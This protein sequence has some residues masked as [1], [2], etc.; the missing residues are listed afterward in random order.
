MS[1]GLEFSETMAGT[2]RRADG[3]GGGPFRID[4]DVRTSKLLSPFGTTPGTYTGKLNA[5]GL[6]SGTAITGTLDF[7]PLKKHRLGYE[8]TTVADDGNSYRFDGWKTIRG[9]RLLRAFTTLPGKI[10]DEHDNV[11]GT[12]LLRFHLK[13]TPAFVLGFRI[14]RSGA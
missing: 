12:A 9:I 1:R 14:R 13:T 7:S 11:V 2:W 4:I 5:A 10:Y 3:D 6:A 8:F